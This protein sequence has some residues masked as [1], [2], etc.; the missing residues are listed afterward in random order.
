MKFI[1]ILTFVLVSSTV[2]KNAKM[3]KRGGLR[4]NTKIA[5]LKAFAYRRQDPGADGPPPPKGKAKKKGPSPKT[6]PP[7]PGP[8]NP[9]SPGAD[10]P[11]SPGADAPGSPGA[12]SPPSPG[13]DTSGGTETGT[14]NN[15]PP[16][17]PQ[18][19]NTI[20]TNTGNPIQQTQSSV[21]NP[22]FGGTLETPLVIVK[23]DNTGNS[24]NQ[25]SIGG[26]N[27]NTQNTASNSN[28]NTSNTPTGTTP[29]SSPANPKTTS[30]T[31]TINPALIIG[32]T[33]G[34]LLLIVGGMYF[35]R[36]KYQRKNSIFDVE[37]DHVDIFTNSE[38]NQKEI[39]FESEPLPPLLNLE[40]DIAVP[41]IAADPAN[42]YGY[43]GS[44]HLSE[45]IDS[46]RG[47]LGT[48]STLSGSL[49]FTAYID[50][51][52]VG[53]RYSSSVGTSLSSASRRLT[54]AA[55]MEL[56]RVGLVPN[57]PSTAIQS[58]VPNS[59]S[60]QSKTDSFVTCP[61]IDVQENN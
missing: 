27:S 7:P 52:Q 29:N 51:N 13:S 47:S 9:G 54:G 21:I 34:A 14:S 44:V 33:F 60:T 4:I 50:I 18:P 32:L 57:T 17:R 59:A 46:S 20:P 6:G 8:D 37:G 53:Q 42:R 28:S 48:I 1:Q 24:N 38:S 31:N 56:D 58:S 5:Q 45:M 3:K 61:E 30:N 39:E 36:T 23:S 40:M 11:P 25:Q 41:D 16:I 43:A 2:A 10:S 22:V 12:D 26:S 49:P 15:T 19:S 55:F 35:G